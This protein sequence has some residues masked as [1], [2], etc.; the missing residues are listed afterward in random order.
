MTGGEPT[1]RRDIVEIVALAK[2]K[3]FE[4]VGLSTNGYRLLNL[5]EPLKAAGLDQI[6]ISIDSLDPKKFALLSG[7]DCGD[8]VI[9]A[10]HKA[11]AM[12][13]R[14]VKVNA[15]LLREINDREFPSFLSWVQ[16]TPISLRFIELMPTNENREFF[17]KHHFR[18]QIWLDSL[19][20][21]GWTEITKSKE[22]GP[23]VEFSHPSSKGE[24]GFITP[25]QST[26]CNS[27]NRLRV[28]SRGALRLCL[29]GQGDLPLRSLLKRGDQTSSLMTAI[30][31]AVLNKK[32]AH[33]LKQGDS[34]DTRTLSSIGG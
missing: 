17:K 14:K 27:C 6:N 18:A 24:I 33:N 28:S 4:T 15:V 19:K 1:L 13:F 11:V 32:Q 16:S 34:G 23:A 8:Q 10:T 12:N 5:L 20:Q 2:N 26:F 3:G 29:F 25:F 7:K 30:E 9:L 31:E 21:Q 22:S